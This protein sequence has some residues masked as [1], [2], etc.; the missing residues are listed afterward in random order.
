MRWP[1]VCHATP[2]IGKSSGGEVMKAS[3]GIL[4]GGASAAILTAGWLTAPSALEPSED[5]DALEPDAPGGGDV[6]VVDGP[7]VTNIRGDYQVRL[8][9]E[10]GEVVAVE[11]PVAGTEASESRR[12]SAMALPVLEERILEAQSG[13]VDYVSG[14]SYTSPAIVESAEAAFDEAGL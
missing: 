5:Q 12:I 8:I 14:A 3:R 6:R 7:V 13:D 11:F 2:F 1:V 4:V 9:I 10:A